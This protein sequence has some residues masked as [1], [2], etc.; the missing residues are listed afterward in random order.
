MLY[1]PRMVTFIK[2]NPK[3]KMHLFI[4]RMLM[5]LMRVLAKSVIREALEDT[6]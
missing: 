4:K 1:Y 6:S 3:Y 2:L 5:D